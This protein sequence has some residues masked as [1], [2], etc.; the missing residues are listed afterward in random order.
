MRNSGSR[1]RSFARELIS[2][3]GPSGALTRYEK[4]IPSFYEVSIRTVSLSHNNACLAFAFADLPALH[5]I[6]GYTDATD[7]LAT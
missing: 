5:R 3:S 1:R 6:S 7:N 4:A 2:R